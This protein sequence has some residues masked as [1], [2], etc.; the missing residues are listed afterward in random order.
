MSLV[1]DVA[2]IRAFLTP[3]H[4]ETAHRVA[5]YADR[6]IASLPPPADDS[7]ARRQARDL[8]ST[9]GA[10]GWFAPILDQDLRACCL[11]REALAAGSPLADAVFALQALGALPLLLAGS[12]E[13][14]RRWLTPLREGG[15]M[16]SFAMTEH[17][18]GSD[19]AAIATAARKDGAEYV[20][21]GSKSFI[22]NG[23]IADYYAVFATT[24]PAAQSKGLSC[25]IVPADAP[26]FAFERPLVLSAPHPL[27]EIAFT[28]CRVPAANR[29]GAEGEGYKIGLATLDRLRAT[30]GAAACGMAAR[31]LAEALGHAAE[32]RQFGKPLAEFQ[33][34]QEKLARM[35]TDIGLAQLACVQLARLKERDALTPV[36]VS[37]AKR[38]H[39]AMALEAARGARDLLGANGITLAYPPIRHLLNLETVKTYEG[40][41]DVHTLVLG[42]HITGLDAFA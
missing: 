30:V 33:L 14:K 17:E 27:G 24:D 36:Q 29:V 39:V 41:H 4:L 32:R 13:L 19:V 25:F 12:D 38:A 35:Y 3:R 21:N 18:A 28:D 6:E 7:A 22:S 1:P 34:V 31:A 11:V 16:A 40:T 37:F 26:G 10:A 8:V 42:K 2:P 23:G 9:L 5:A 15:V 20:L